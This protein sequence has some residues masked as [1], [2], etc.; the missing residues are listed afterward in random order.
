MIYIYKKYKM[1]IYIYIHTYTYTYIYKKNSP[2]TRN[3]YREIKKSDDANYYFVLRASTAV[4][5]ANRFSKRDAEYYI[6]KT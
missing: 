1:Y 4:S 2:Y 6:N 3:D 5:L